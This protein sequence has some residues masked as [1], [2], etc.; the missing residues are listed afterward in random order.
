M[1]TAVQKKPKSRP[2]G[3]INED[4]IPLNAVH[5]TRGKPS[6]NMT[7]DLYTAV[8]KKPR[9]TE[10]APPIP[11]HTVEELYT[12]VVKTPKGKAED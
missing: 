5:T 10:I 4:E 1:Y 7:E 2:H 11:P 12:A 3:D 9:G 6:H 8:M